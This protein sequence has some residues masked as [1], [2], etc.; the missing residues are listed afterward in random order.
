MVRFRISQDRPFQVHVQTVL[1]VAMM[2]AGRG[3]PLRRP[4]QKASSGADTQV[5]G[6]GTAP[7]G[8]LS[9]GARLWGSPAACDTSPSWSPSSH[10]GDSSPGMGD[11]SEPLLAATPSASGRFCRERGLRPHVG[12]RGGWTPQSL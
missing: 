12:P 1:K 11:A 10:A 9:Q 5:H 6:P 7:W 2:L 4:G 8:L 3:W